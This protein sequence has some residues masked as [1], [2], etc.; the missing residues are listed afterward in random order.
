MCYAF[1][2]RSDESQITDPILFSDFLLDPG[3]SSIP[4]PKYHNLPF[5]LT[6]MDFPHPSEPKSDIH[7]GHM[8]DCG[9]RIDV[10]RLYAKRRYLVASI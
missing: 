8:G 9:I 7:S 4:F 5:S 10:R 2:K 1:Y 6:K 3:F